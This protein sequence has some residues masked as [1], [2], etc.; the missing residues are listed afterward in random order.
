M[1]KKNSVKTPMF[2]KIKPNLILNAN[3]II[4]IE[5]H[6]PEDEEA[7]GQITFCCA[8]GGKCTLTFPNPMVTKSALRF[9]ESKMNDLLVDLV[10]K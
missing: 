3:D 1:S 7:K 8:N 9:I 2:L 6:I 5:T 4:R 10:N